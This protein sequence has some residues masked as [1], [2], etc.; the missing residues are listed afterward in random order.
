MKTRLLSLAASLLVSAVLMLPTASHAVT[1]TT[2]LSQDFSSAV[3]PPAGWSANYLG[4]YNY[5]Y[6]GW[7]W[8]SGGNGG[9][10]GSAVASTTYCY[11]PGCN[12]GNG[13][14]SLTTP[15]INTS[16]L[17]AADSLFVD[18]DLWYPEGYYQ[19][20]LSP[21]QEN[22]VVVTS[23]ST[24]LLTKK[25]PGDCTF[26]TG[27]TNTDPS[28]Y[29]NSTYWRHYHLY[30]PAGATTTNVV[31]T[32][33]D[34]GGWCYYGYMYTENVAFDNVVITD[35]HYDFI[36]VI[37]PLTLNFP[38]EP[39]G[40]QSLS[41]YV[42]L[43]NPS[44]RTINF[45][46][47]VIAGANP[48]DFII[49]RNLASIAPGMTDSVGV[50]YN[51]GGVGA[52]NGV[53]QFNT[54]ADNVTSVSVGLSGFGLAPT[55]VVPQ[56]L[57]LFVHKFVRF[58]Q[59]ITQSF[60]VTNIGQ[61]P[62]NIFAYPQSFI[63]G[64]FPNMYKIVKLPIAPIPGGASDTV[65][66]SFT[67]MIEG[68]LGA[69]LNIAS[70]A[71]NGTQTI[72]MRGIGVLPR[73]TINN[74]NSPFDNVIDMS[75]D[76]VNIGTQKCIQIP[77]TNNGTDTLVLRKNYLSSKDYDFSITPFTAADTAIAPTVTKWM[78]A[79]LTPL[80]SGFRVATIRVFTNIPVTFPVDP[81][82]DPNTFGPDT[83]SFFVNLS[84]TGVPFGTLAVTGQD[85]IGSPLN[86]QA[87][88]NDT[89]WNTGSA[90]IT[91]KGATLTMN[92]SFDF[93]IMGL[94]FPATLQA[95]KFIPFTICGTPPVSGD[96]RTLFTAS[97]LTGESNVSASL[98]VDV[99]G[100]NLCSTTTATK[101]LPATTCICS[102]G[103]TAI[104]TVANCG[105]AATTYT[106]SITPAT[107]TD[108]KILGLATS[109]LEAGHI[110][111]ATFKVLY[112]PTARGASVAN[113]VV[114]GGSGATVAL[115]GKGGAPN[116]SG[117][118]T[119]PTTAAGSVS[120]NFA[121]NVTN[122]GE[123]DWTPG[124]PMVPASDPFVY[125]SG[126][127]T[128]I[129]AGGTG[130]LMFTFNPTASGTF[131]AMDITFPSASCAAIPAAAITLTGGTSSGVSTLTASQGFSLEQN[132]P[133]PFANH[134]EVTM[135]LPQSAV[136]RLA[137]IDQT[138]KAV[139]TLVNE[140]MS[141]GSFNVTIDA[142]D[143]ASGTYYYQMTA[144]DVTLTRQMV[145]QK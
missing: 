100:Q 96:H 33:K 2:L 74:A 52:R 11:Q 139:R 21:Y 116:I 13:S 134:T 91:I 94:T 56:N 77:F 30:V 63:S 28:S 138:G 107:A 62:L 82:V 46:N 108:Y 83:S 22:Q 15:S 111:V 110:G 8:S 75:F 117:T 3:F 129:P 39:I 145:I 99:F 92:D 55:I 49:T 133:N 58:R 54:D 109:P 112:T 106:A 79:C 78:T 35:K 90:D 41:L 53:L 132:Y 69:T 119:A 29:T 31:F 98:G 84:G 137:I 140:R 95:G 121:V 38:N 19:L 144:G 64:D 102:T 9:S 5:Y 23:G 4:R 26:Y 50:A 114:T 17:T 72:N 36:N 6:G 51:P 120:A 97:G 45:S 103:D 14:I 48:N 1:T 142:S 32:V 136:V 123:C 80:R 16:S 115:T 128:S 101:P 57:T 60:L 73:L 71:S 27:G 126:G 24:T 66:I 143:L 93:V 124:T 12:Y 47:F 44:A 7:Y 67:P 25:S 85:S 37:G 89:L 113:F 88:L 76:S 141:A 131:N 87:C 86:T 68:G 34:N 59:T 135:T 125:K 20:Y 61:V 122:T 127:T 104:I 105:D 130:T 43:K 10:N 118:G 42:T 65:T 18:F 70:N 40:V 81:P